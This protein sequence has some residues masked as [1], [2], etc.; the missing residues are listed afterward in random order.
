MQNVQF[1]IDRQASYSIDKWIVTDDLLTI[2]KKK[3]KWILSR[4]NRSRL[5]RD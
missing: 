3:K 4:S 1:F 2:R 5:N